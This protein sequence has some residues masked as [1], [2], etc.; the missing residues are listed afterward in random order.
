VPVIG[1]LTVDLVANTASFTSDLDKAGTGL[2]NL[3]NTAKEAGKN[4]DFSMAEAK[5]SIALVGDEIGVHIPRHLQALI[6][7]IP[8][9]G[10]AFAEM[11]PIVGVIAAIAIIAK[12]IAKTEEAKEKMA[13]GWD[14]FDV[15]VQNVFN[16]LDDKLLQVGKRAD[17]LAGRHLEALHKELL[18]IDHASLHQLAEEFGKLEK[19]G[20]S[21]MVEMKSSWYEINSGSQGASNALTRFNGEYDLL[22]A[23]GDKKGAYDKL[24]GTLDSANKEL[25]KMEEAQKVTGIHNDKMIDSQ[26][27]L[28]S[29]LQDQLKVTEKE[30]AVTKGEE[31]NAKTEYAQQ[32]QQRQY[33]TYEEQQKGLNKRFEAEKRYFEETEKLAKKSAEEKRKIT[34]EEAEATAEVLAK[35]VKTNEAFANES[36]KHDLAMAK[37]QESAEEQAAKHSLAMRKSS[38]EEATKA[39]IEAS[40]KRLAVEI[41]A[42]NR[43]AA[44]L[45]QAAIKDTLKLQ[46]IEDKKTQLIAQSTAE[47]TRIREAAEQRQYTVVTSAEERIAGEIA[48]TATQSIF[49]GKN[50]AASFEKMGEQMLES[51]TENILK[52]VVLQNFQKMSDAKVAAANAYAAVSAIPVVGPFLAPAAAGAAF[53]GVMAFERGGEIPGNGAVPIIG[54]GGETVVT[55]ALTDQVK[56]NTGGGGSPITIHMG[57]VSALDADGVD[58]VLTRHA[59]TIQKHVSSALRKQ[60]KR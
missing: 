19:A 15:T 44:I 14:S 53:A 21:L 9:V 56:H 26:R 20:Q 16:S 27:L 18:L 37:I 23:K 49:Q 58:E 13:R 7:E 42:L 10:L 29:I 46:Q 60:N 39:E 54:H 32:E 51:A 34:D 52:M 24:V 3:G 25:A 6:A 31:G 33:A 36:M 22:L 40:E 48:K 47:Q 2:D 1:T 35:S 43:E 55:K 4:I 5:G 59:S 57:N 11:L 45:E 38:A 8:G 30:A 17:E 41:N 50:M 12:L 28:V